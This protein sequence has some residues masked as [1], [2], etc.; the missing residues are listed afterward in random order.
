MR[1]PVPLRMS[2]YAL[3]YEVV[4]ACVCICACASMWACARCL[5]V[6]ARLNLAD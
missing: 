5:F 6:R 1:L 2:A 3:A 4:F